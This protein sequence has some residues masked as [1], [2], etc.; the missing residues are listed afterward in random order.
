MNKLQITLFLIFAISALACGQSQPKKSKIKKEKLSEWKSLSN[1]KFEIKY[2]SD[3]DVDQS[4]L[5]GTS[6]LI[7]SQIT[8]ESD[9]FKE[10]VNL[11]VQDLSE[12]KLTLDTFVESS[13]NQI[14]T[15]FVNG[16][17]ISSDRIK[18]NGREY[19][20]L[21]FAGEQQIYDLQFEQYYW[22]IEDEAYV[23]TLT[24]EI[25]QFNNYKEVG[26]KILNTFKIK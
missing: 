7:F 2:P 19:H 12:N 6:F 5:M 10:N 23:L 15:A 25:D 18:N 20:K 9:N 13:E 3:W 1:D 21:V 24:C 11:L 26:E 17:L 4:G 14:E 8:D 16:K 22:V